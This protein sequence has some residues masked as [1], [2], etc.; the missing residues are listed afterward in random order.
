MRSG[1]PAP[2]ACVTPGKPLDLTASRFPHQPGGLSQGS[3]SYCPR[4]PRPGSESR[5]TWNHRPGKQTCL[6]GGALAAP[7]RHRPGSR[8]L[9]E[10][11]WGSQVDVQVDGPE[12]LPG[13]GAAE[14]GAAP[15]RWGLGPQ[16]GSVP[17]LQG[18]NRI[19]R[20][21]TTFVPTDARRAETLAP[22]PPES[23]GLPQ[24][25]GRAEKREGAL[26]PLPTHTGHPATPT[27]P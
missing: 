20:I 17:G 13:S 18:F 4:A 8:L 22:N 5:S 24:R 14:A 9:G 15:A 19:S 10:P 7:V 26:V 3:L 11:H 16:V 21:L 6:C 1:A 25:P 23:T 27:L 2:T 12:H